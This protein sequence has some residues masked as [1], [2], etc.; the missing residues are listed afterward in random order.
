LLADG[1]A[2]KAQSHPG[3]DGYWVGYT[4]SGCVPAN[5]QSINPGRGN[6]ALLLRS[7]F[8]FLVTGDRS[9]ADP[10]KTELL[11]QIKVSGT[12]FGDSNKWCVNDLNHLGG[13]NILE[14]VPWV[15]R[16]VTAFDYLNA[17][18]YTGFTAAEKSSVTNWFKAAAGLWDSAQVYI[19]THYAAY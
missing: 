15:I 1:N 3:S 4:G 13:G 2:F 7:A 14:I 16:L 18:G 5:D 6:G 9:Y 11:N 12:N 10:V 17:G 19:V 8:V